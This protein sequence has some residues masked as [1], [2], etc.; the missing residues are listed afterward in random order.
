MTASR[1]LAPAELT[2]DAFD[3]SFT[4]NFTIIAQVSGQ[5]DRGRLESALRRLEVRHPLLRARVDRSGG[6]LSFV[7]GEAATIP[8]RAL[9]GAP[10]SLWSLAATSLNH[11]L[12]DD[13]GPRAELT[14]IKHSEQ[15]STLLL[16]L[17]HLVSDGSSGIYAMRD[18][19]A[20]AG[21][22]ALQLA[23]IEQPA[24]NA[25]YPR[26]HGGIGW[27]LRAY[28]MILRSSL[29]AKP[30]RLR[31]PSV[32]GRAK[33]APPRSTQLQRMR[34]S[35]SDTQELSQRAR[36]DR[37]TVHGVLSAALARAV[38][39]ELTQGAGTPARAQG[40]VP[41]R[42]LHPVDLRRYL[43]AS[44]PGSATPGEAVGYYVSS[45]ETDHKVDPD[46]S[47]AA[48]AREITEAVRAGK[49]QE[50][51]LL[52]API[53]GP[54]LTGRARRAGDMPGFRD[55]VEQKVVFD[56]F[57]ITNLGPLENL[58]VT[59]EQ[60]SLFIED[61]YFVSAGSVFSS[62]GASV[63]TFRGRLTLTFA[64]VEPLV[65]GPVALRVFDQ[66]GSELR[67]YLGH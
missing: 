64:W 15:A 40:G 19:I 36:R 34:L 58:A 10:E 12:W 35:E 41:E 30:R 50:L 42:I 5:L 2:I 18:L 53:A 17:H 67:R 22:P 52:T 37:S 56:T 13:A 59:P 45:L 47:F 1:P 33:D 28:R 23:P 61:L 16:C 11:K 54:L 4:L 48:L 31:V 6:R 7:A 55:L 9:E 63:T 20:L 66:L 25:F 8:L 39:K 32:G 26:G 62:L 24:Q 51:P 49:Q 29:G 27:K 3:R 57:G 44:R 60:G 46:G 65:E 14:W 38:A 21:N 43:Q